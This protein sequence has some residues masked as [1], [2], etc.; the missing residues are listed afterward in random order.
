MVDQYAFVEEG[1]S[2]TPLRFG[3]LSVA[4]PIASAERWRMGIERR[5]PVCDGAASVFLLPCPPSGGPAVT[6]TVT[7][8]PNVGANAFRVYAYVPCA[9]VGWGNDLGELKA[10]SMSAL[11]NGEGR[12]VE[13]VFWSGAIDFG[14]GTVYP[15][16]AAN[17]AV[18]GSPQ[19]AAQILLQ[20][21]AATPAGS[22]ALDP[23]IALGALEQAL[24]ECYGGEGVI[25]V[26]RKAL[27]QLDHNYVVHQSG[28]QLR[29]LSGNVVAGYSGGR[30]PGPDGSEPSAGNAW[31]YG[32]GAV[33]VYRSPIV[34]IGE[35][36][37]EFV[38]RTDNSTVYVVARDYLVTFDCCLI[39]VQATLE[40]AV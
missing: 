18:S 7:G 38:G 29:T 35:Q 27:A 40:G 5:S 16:L 21:P 8:S 3:L 17:T 12:V 2:F 13:S 10:R 24:A 23:V 32:T 39:A 28:Q 31:F 14:S 4:E 26:P 9:P 19:G 22:S 34:E 20:P 33:Q 1:P 15:H 11:T 37:A 36:P 25:H 30:Y 6:P